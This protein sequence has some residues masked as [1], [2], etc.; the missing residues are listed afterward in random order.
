MN[1]QINVNTTDTKATKASKAT[2]ATKS[3]KATKANKVNDV[4][5]ITEIINTDTVKPKVIKTRKHNKT[6]IIND[7]DND[8]VINIEPIELQNTI[9]PITSIIE[10]EQAQEQQQPQTVNININTN[11]NTKI[12]N[13]K[14]ILVDSRCEGRIIDNTQCSRRKYKKNK[15][16]KSHLRISFNENDNTNT[17]TNTNTITN[18]ITPIDTQITTLSIKNKRGRK[19][20]VL[21]DQ[22]RYDIEYETLSSELIN[23][24]KVLIDNNHNLYT[25]DITNPV[26]LGKKTLDF[27]IDEQQVPIIQ[28]LLTQ[29]PITQSLLTQSLDIIDKLNNISLN[30]IDLIT[31]TVNQEEQQLQKQLQQKQLQKHLPYNICNIETVLINSDF[32]VNFNIHLKKLSKILT[33]KG[34]F[35]TYDPDEHSGINLKYYF[36]KAN[37]TQGY[38]K[39]EKHC[40]TKEKNPVC[41]KVTI[42]IFRTGSIIITG[43]RKLE[44]L[45][46]AYEL[47]K[48]LLE[49]HMQTIKIIEGIE[50]RNAK[51][52]ALENNKNRKLSRKPQLFYIKKKDIINYPIVC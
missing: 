51:T 31:T 27:K 2:K 1:I 29:I 20:K 36:N 42:L 33:S 9:I 15:F 34:L 38:C 26:Y 39:C 8:I 14:V 50:E 40:A 35:N 4:I 43:S 13:K 12:S 21:V 37:N 6:N 11:T 41:T 52:T 49:E 7:N 32:S 10:H 17:N 19:R 25:F 47:I 3:T 48:T 24:H 23:G 45:K 18:T 44:H 22:R 28:S 16:C 30:D 5:Q 46:S